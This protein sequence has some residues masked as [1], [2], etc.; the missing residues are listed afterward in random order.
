MIV[1]V[2][3]V[4]APG[5]SIDDIITAEDVLPEIVLVKASV[6]EVDCVVTGITE[7]READV[8]V[9]I[10]VE[11]VREEDSKCCGVVAE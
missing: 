10:T 5:I 1:L 8:V 7:V 9:A 11:E 3:K 2:E 6:V 4:D